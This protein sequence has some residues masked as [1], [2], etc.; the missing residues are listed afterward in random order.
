M[1]LKQRRLL[2]YS[3]IFLFLIIAPFALLYA[4]GRTI[5][6]SRFEIQKT[7]SIIIESEPDRADIFLNN[8]RPILFFNQIF[9][10]N[11]VPRTNTKLSNLTPGNY[12]LRL[13]LPGYLAWEKKTTIRANEVTHVGPIRLFKQTKP[14]LQ[15]TLENKQEIIT[16]PDG[17]TV[18]SLLDQSLTTIQVPEN[19]QTKLVVPAKKNPS[20][21]WSNDQESFILNDTLVINRSGQLVA[22]LK[23]ELTFQPSFVRWNADNHDSIYFIEKNRLE[24]FIFA[25]KKS[26][27]VMEISSLLKSGELLDYRPSEGHTYFTLRKKQESEIILLYSN[28]L[29]RQSSASLP[30]GTYHFINDIKN[31]ILLLETQKKNLYLIEQPLPLFFSPRV[32]LVAQNYSLGHWNKNSVLYVTPFEIRK[33]EDNQDKLIARLGEAVIG[34]EL[35]SKNNDILFATKKGLNIL[36]IAEQAFNQTITLGEVEEISHLLI[37]NDNTLYFIGQYN[38]QYGIY[39]LN[40]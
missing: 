22:N 14:E 26:E 36:P 21:V 7:G 37:V 16:S 15:Q 11:S 10:K 27:V 6:W 33:W 9:Q 8:K 40:F 2:F 12:L 29:T 35:I 5:N 23:G 28:S 30:V 3:F 24:Q 17:R 20:V 1:S 34:L 25:T 39:K 4:T 31:K 38:N 32:T 19:N 13:E 18:I